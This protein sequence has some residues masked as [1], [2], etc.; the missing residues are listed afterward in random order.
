M[1]KRWCALAVLLVAGCEGPGPGCA[2][3]AAPTA[4][5]SDSSRVLQYWIVE[6]RPVLAS[7]AVPDSPA[8]RVFRDEISARFDT[9]PRALLRAQLPHVEGGDAAN[10]RAVLDGEAGRI[11]QIRCL[12]ALLLSVQA[13]RTV[14]QGSSMFER[15]TEFAAWILEREGA[16][17]IWYF[18]VDQPGIGGLAPVH[19][20]VAADQER[21]WR[22]R[23]LL[24][25]HN[26]FP[27]EEG[28]LG[29]VVPSASDVGY[30]RIV[31]DQFGAPLASITNG[32]HT[33]D[34]GVGDLEALQGG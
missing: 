9:N 33:L 15:P 25:N 3:D 22:V 30:Y 10:V 5:L 12:E 20:M 14:S 8:L 11:R 31:M 19:G 1:L 7:S 16:L 2:L 13:E 24:H 17:K 34:L 32:F 23:Q 18:T 26:F 6:D 4:I 27:E 28:V 29:G 21:G